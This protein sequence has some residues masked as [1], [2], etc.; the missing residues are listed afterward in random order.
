MLLQVGDII[1]G[2]DDLGGKLVL[3]EK[4]CRDKKRHTYAREN[5]L[6]SIFE[7]SRVVMHL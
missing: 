1:P 7:R 3:N 6:H 4:T 5:K 2:T